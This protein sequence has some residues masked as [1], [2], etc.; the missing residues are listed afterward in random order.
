VCRTYE[1]ELLRKDGARVPVLVGASSN[2]PGRGSVWFALDITDRARAVRGLR[3]SVRARDEFLAAVTHELRTPLTPIHLQVQDLLERSQEKGVEHIDAGWLAQ[4]LRPIERATTRLARLLD[5][6]LVVS[7]LTVGS[8][9]LERED[10]DLVTL[11]RGVVDRMRFEIDRAACAL[12]I[13]ATGV[14]PE[15]HWDRAR[16]EEVVRQLLVNAI[17][18]GKGKPIEI[19]IASGATTSSLAIRDHGIGIS[20]EAQG[21]LFQRFERFVS[22]QNYGGLGIGLWLAEKIVEAHGGGIRLSSSP[23]EGSQFIVELPRWPVG[24]EHRATA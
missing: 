13:R 4:Q 17:R 22:L 15:G 10:V 8:L 18:Y 2:V 7:R 14:A 5:N 3:E 6:L 12:S 21:Q 23:G 24:A 20:K 16:L 9:Q 19:E 11:V 1:K